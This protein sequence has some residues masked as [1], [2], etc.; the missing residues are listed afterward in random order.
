VSHRLRCAIYT[1]KSTEEGLDQAFNSLDAQRE[2]C[3]AYVRSQAGEGWTPLRTQYA[4]GGYSGGN[5]NRPAMQQLLADVDAGRVDVIV[6]YK[7]DR[8]TRSLMDFAKIVE[9]L[10]ARGVSFVSVTQAFNTTTSMGRLT[11]NVLLSFAQFEREVTGERIRDKIAASKARGMW[12]GGNVPLGYD[13]GDRELVVNTEEAE[14]VR[15]IFSRYVELG[16]GIA[17]MHELRREGIV[18]KRW[19][20]RSGKERGGGEF[21]CGA[22]YYLLQ[23]RLYLGEIVHK[24]VRHAG[25]HDAIVSAELF[26]AVSALL[27]ARRHKRRERPTRV[28]TCHLA[29]LVYDASDQPMGTSFS[30]G[31][32]GRLYRYYVS[33]SLDPN[34]DCQGKRPVRVPAGAVE[35]TVQRSLG[36][37][38][39]RPA[40]LSWDGVRSIVHRVQLNSE[41]THVVL[42]ADAIRE[43]L[44]SIEAAALRLARRAGPDTISAAGGHLI[45]AVDWRPSARRLPQIA[46]QGYDDDGRLALKSAHALLM[47][48]QMSPLEPNEHSNAAA[49]A[50][51]RQRHLMA[52]GLLAPDL[53]RSMLEGRF[54]SLPNQL[55][56]NA[57]LAWAD[58]QLMIE[59]HEQAT[60]T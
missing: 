31:R 17:L 40:H 38:L 7:V 21:S 55:R 34:R 48:H 29:G 20:S 14:Q 42:V 15:H 54:H 27:A 60:G 3:E 11:L 9:R 25:A 28:A 57:P 1:R 16:S 24:D 35:A 45:L 47:Q 22:L 32:G 50:W 44:E 43:P 10:D 39:N 53:Q 18:S 19:T 51:Q 52:L 36:R 8:L 26:D 46:A 30:Y 6:V 33:G 37:L 12:M 13:L 2:A 56:V 4:D 23:N 58:Q 5:L 41:Q 59:R 49:P